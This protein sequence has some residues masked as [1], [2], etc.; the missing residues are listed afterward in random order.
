MGLETGSLSPSTISTSTS[1]PSSLSSTSAS[2]SASVPSSIIDT[3]PTS[4][5]SSSLEPLSPSHNPLTSSALESLAKSLPTYLAV[6]GSVLGVLI[7]IALGSWWYRRRKRMNRFGSDE[8]YE[9]EWRVVRSKREEGDLEKGR[10]SPN[11]TEN[12]GDNNNKSATTTT[13]KH[14]NVEDPSEMYTITH[15]TPSKSSPNL[16][17]HVD[18][19]DISPASSPMSSPMSSRTGS[20]ENLVQK[21]EEL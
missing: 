19:Y 14:G 10:N 4:S 11:C 13:H 17:V 20:H 16:S 12:G 6:G 9:E 1:H 15:A 5:W 3:S 8:E 21:R 7:V 2:A 18:Q